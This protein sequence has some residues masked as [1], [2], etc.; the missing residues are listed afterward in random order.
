MHMDLVLTED[1]AMLANTAREFFSGTSGIARLRRLRDG[2]EPLAYSPDV[3]AKMVELGFLS[4][5]FSEADGGLGLGLAETVLVTEALGRE[6]APEPFVPCVVLAAGLLSLLGNADQKGAYLAKALTGDTRLALAHEEAGARGTL[7]L[8]RTKAQQ[9][10]SGYRLTGKK[11]P[12]LGGYGADAFLVSART[13]GADRD[14]QGISVFIVPHDAKGLRV[15]RLTRVD[16]L[17]AAA[18]ELRDVEVPTSAVVGEVGD[19]L[20]AL[21][22][23]VDRATVALAGEMLGA[24]SSAFERTLAYLR[25]REQFGAKIGTFQALQHRAARMFIDVELSRSVVMAAARAVDEGAPNAKALV[26]VAKARAGDA[27]VGISNE[28]I[29]MHGGI[30]MTDEHDIGFFLK[31]AKVT[32]MTFGDGAFHRARFATLNGF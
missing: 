26:S 25:E 20:S 24:M 18:L 32:E 10:Q 4:M 22:A 5:P 28:A 31:R 17:N 14:A 23:A 19:A 2:N 13:S 1:Q 16:S 8:C 6:L 27:F 21:E 7:S 12:V 3:W 30:G 15:E 29:Q 9:A 11:S